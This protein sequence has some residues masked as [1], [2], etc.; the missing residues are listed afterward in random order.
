MG[1][2]IPCFLTSLLLD[3]FRVISFFLVSSLLA[4]SFFNWCLISHVLF[5]LIPFDIYFMCWFDL[6]YIICWLGFWYNLDNLFVSHFGVLSSW[7]TWCFWPNCI[8]LGSRKSMHA[9]LLVY[10]CYGMIVFLDPI[11]REYSTES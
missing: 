2:L 4:G 10:I 5:D 11:Y 8:S 6:S 7:F 3:I 1:A 9:Y